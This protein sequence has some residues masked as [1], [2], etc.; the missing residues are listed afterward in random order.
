MFK[1]NDIVFL[2][3]KIKIIGQKEILRASASDERDVVVIKSRQLGLSELGVMSCINWLDTHS[4]QGVRGL[5][6]FPTYR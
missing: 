4:A 6:T 2:Y 1:V 3:W 5:Y